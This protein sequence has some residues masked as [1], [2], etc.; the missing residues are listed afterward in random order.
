MDGTAASLVSPEVGGGCL[1]AGE[2]EF[3][4][5]SFYQDE[6]GEHQ[7]NL[8]SFNLTSCPPCALTPPPELLPVGHIAVSQSVHLLHIFIK[9]INPHS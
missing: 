3:L 9:P 4:E 6:G 1:C 2:A 5:W 7:I 8:I